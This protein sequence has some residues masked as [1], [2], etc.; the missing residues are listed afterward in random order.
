MTAESP[1]K[2]HRALQGGFLA[3][4]T[5]RTTNERQERVRTALAAF[6]AK[7]D[8]PDNHKLERTRLQ[9]IAYRAGLAIEDWRIVRAV[10]KK[11]RRLI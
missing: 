11:R 2:T 3:G 9:A 10:L 4:E 6:L 1:K 5:T 7:H 8:L